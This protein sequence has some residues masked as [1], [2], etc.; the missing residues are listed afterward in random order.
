MIRRSLVTRIATHMLLISLMAISSF[1]ASYIISD[2]M[3]GDAGALNVAG[4]LRMQTFRIINNLQEI[5]LDGLI[6]GSAEKLDY[7][8]Q[9]FTERLQK[10]ELVYAIPRAND[11]NLH[12]IY[13]AIRDR[14]LSYTLPRIRSMDATNR[15]E[16]MELEAILNA[17]Y[18]LID[19]MVSLLERSTDNKVRLQI[20]I[21][22]TFMLL[23]F[24]AIVVAFLDI[25]EKVV[26]PLKHLMAQVKEVR[27]GNF[28]VRNDVPDKDEISDLAQAVND[29]SRDLSY[30]YRNLEKI[31]SQKTLELERSHKALQLLHDASRLLYENSDNLCHNAVPMLK[32]LEKLIDIGSINLYIED[33]RQSV[34]VMS[35]RNM[36]RPDYCRDLK[37][38]A[39][40]VEGSCFNTKLTEPAV[41]QSV[42]HLYLPVATA[43]LRLG[44]LDVA[45]PR[46]RQLSDRAVR[47]LQTLA[48]QLA[49]AIYI[50][51]QMQ[52]SQQISLLEERTIIA[53]ELHDSLAQS[54]S[55]LKMQVSR[56]Q[57]QQQK[58]GES[59]RQQTILT[60]IRTGVNSAYRQLRE[61][62]TTFRLQ[63][64]KP[65]LRAALDE[66]VR[67][68][69]ERMG[70]VLDLDFN[71]PPD[72][73]NPNE[74]IHVLQIVREALSNATKHSG[75]TAVKV[76]VAFS[77]G[78][79][80][81]CIC[82]NGC[83]L[84]D[85]KVPDQ[86]YGLIIMRDRSISLGGSI[87]LY[88]QASGGVRMDLEFTPVGMQNQTDRSRV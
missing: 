4:S 73:L 45:Y 14:W 38:K 48:D 5:R 7:T 42:E 54:L 41:N 15:M 50:K 8:V 18:L 75:A 20:F 17:Q 1:L 27:Q 67:E 43:G 37:C 61:L 35:T 79:V 28:V 9:G 10:D 46:G 69:S 83:G 30:N 23:A 39:C 62:L 55:Y 66:T 36:E 64:D 26:I 11:N 49:T 13:E 22:T 86:H 77:E 16:V 2:R 65:G 68:F 57:K 74:E 29:M 21:Q 40:M 59:D 12:V 32:E 19:N 60:E 80:Q 85:G 3:K 76:D 51:R 87:N 82:D 24:A 52:E 78:Q 53:R 44:T 72:L 58:D 6:A 56:L 34:K 84:S 71:L 33:E 47:L 31:V 88:N 63:L 25:R 70:F 81:V